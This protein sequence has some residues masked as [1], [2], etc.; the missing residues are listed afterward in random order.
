MTRTHKTMGWVKERIIMLV[1]Y[2]LQINYSKWN[3]HYHAMNS[4][5]GPTLYDL[6]YRNHCH[7]LW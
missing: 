1:K 3:S 7:Q 6:I 4:K 5:V 2:L